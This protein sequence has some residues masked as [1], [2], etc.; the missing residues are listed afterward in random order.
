M[1]VDREVAGH[2]AENFSD[3]LADCPQIA[4]ATALASIGRLRGCATTLL[5]RLCQEAEHCLSSTTELIVNRPT[6]IL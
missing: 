5:I 6:R 2:V 3:A 1:A 4:A